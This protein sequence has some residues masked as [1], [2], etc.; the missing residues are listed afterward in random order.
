MVLNGNS[1]PYSTGMVINSL[2]AQLRDYGTTNIVNVNTFLEVLHKYAE[3]QYKNDKPFVAECHS[4]YRKLW[5][6]KH[7]L[8]NCADTIH[9][10]FSIVENL[11]YHGITILCYMTRMAQQYNTTRWVLQIFLNGELAA[12]QPQL[13]IMKLDIPPPL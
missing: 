12:S 9:L 3:T 11:M 6:D 5:A 10:A 2:A 8:C 1:W 4:P 13:G 7:L